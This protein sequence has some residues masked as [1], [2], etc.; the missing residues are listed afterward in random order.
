MNQ[1]RIKAKKRMKR[2]LLNAGIWTYFILTLL[3]F[4]SA[5]HTL[6]QKPEDGSYSILPSD[7]ELD[8]I[9]GRL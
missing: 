1:C 5:I 3:I 6:S 2:I 7:K 8:K 9:E 4:F